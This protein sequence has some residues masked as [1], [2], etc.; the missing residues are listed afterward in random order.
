[1]TTQPC[2]SPT[3]RNWDLRCFNEPISTRPSYIDVALANRGTLRVRPDY[4]VGSVSCERILVHGMLYGQGRRGF[5][6]L[7]Q[8]PVMG[9][10]ALLQ[11]RVLGLRRRRKR[12]KKACMDELSTEAVK[13]ALQ[14]V[15]DM[16]RKIV[17]PLAD[18]IGEGMGSCG[19]ALSL[20]ACTQDVSEDRANAD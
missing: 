12:I 15:G 16:L 2:A 6:K 13:Q 10:K 14:P 3:S 11:F 5:A 20:Q 8:F 17:G 1:M 9:R 7:V 19:E 4:N 18:E